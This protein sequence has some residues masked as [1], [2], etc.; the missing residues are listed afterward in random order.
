VTEYSVIPIREI[1]RSQ[2]DAQRKLLIMGVL[3]FSIFFVSV[4]NYVL[5]A[6][7]SMSRRAKMVGVH[8]CSGAGEGHILGLFL[9]ETGILVLVSTVACLLLMLLISI[10]M[11]YFS[12]YYLF[13]SLLI[14]FTGF[15]LA[16][17]HDFQRTQPKIITR[18]A[19]ITNR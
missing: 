17:R 7:A 10:I 13:Y 14:L 1:H 12:I 18:L 8:K 2:P 4:M 6:I 5:A 11:F 9:W 19:I 16:I 15:S 3:G